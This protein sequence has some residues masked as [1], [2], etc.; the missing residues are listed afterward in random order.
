M[1]KKRLNKNFYVKVIIQSLLLSEKSGIVKNKLKRKL[2]LS[3][4]VEQT[5]NNDGWI[6]WARAL[7]ERIRAR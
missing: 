6:K 4:E 3:G 1:K 2:C 7:I 5:N